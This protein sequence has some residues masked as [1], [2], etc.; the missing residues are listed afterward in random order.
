MNVFVYEDFVD[1]FF[2]P[3]QNWT[4]FRGHFY[5]F[6]GIFL[7]SMYRVEDILLGCENV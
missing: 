7:T 3:S 6:Y 1:I 5:A 2:G 4:I